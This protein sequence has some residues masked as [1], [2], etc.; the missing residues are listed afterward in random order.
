MPK[1]RDFERSIG[2][3]AISLA[4]S[5]NAQAIISAER[6][7]R[8]KI[9]YDEP[10]ISIKINLFKKVGGKNYKKYEYKTRLKKPEHGST[11]SPKELLIDAISHHLI[12]KGDRV[13][14][15]QDESL[16]SG[17]KAVMFVIDVDNLFFNMSQNKLTRNIKPEVLEAVMDIA[18]EISKYGREGKKVGT[19]FVITDKDVKK[20]TKQMIINPFE[21]LSEK[22]RSITNPELRETI[23]AF[24]LLD[25]AFIINGEGKVLSAGTYLDIDTKNIYL[26]SGFGTRHRAAAAITQ[27]TEAVAVVVSET[28]GKVR[29]FNE[30]KIAMNL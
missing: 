1:E 27:E 12:N 4:D 2:D 29:V 28:G 15:I 11:I 9:D 21:H 23:I 25:G 7:E 14:C 17:H 30:G 26:P 18:L 8:E 20:Y 19:I 22:E 13:I 10:V 6:D 24:S 16:G 5:I 3:A